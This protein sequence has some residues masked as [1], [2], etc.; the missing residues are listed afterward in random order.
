MN[1]RR[2]SALWLAGALLLTAQPVLAD[3]TAPGA[4]NSILSDFDIIGIA[5]NDYSRITGDNTAF[6]LSEHEIRRG[7]IGVAGKLFDTVKFKAE[8]DID[9]PDDPELI[10]AYISIQPNGGPFVIKLG[11]FKTAN[12]LDEQTS[13]KF[14][15]TLERAAFTDAFELARGVGAGV[16]YSGKRHTL[17]FGVFGRDMEDDVFKGYFVGGRATYE[18]IATDDL[19]VHTGVS[20]RY[21]DLDADQSPFDYSQKPVAHPAGAIVTTGEIAHSDLFVG[22]EAAV[23]KG[24]YWAAAEFGALR[25]DCVTCLSDPFL[26]GG[27]LEVGAFWNGRKN[28][29]GGKFGV[30]KI[31]NSVRDGGHG[32]FSVVARFDTLDLNDSMVNG[33]LYESITFGADWWPTSHTRLGVNVYKTHVE[34]GNVLDGLETAFATAIANGVTEEDA[35]GV[36]VRFQVHI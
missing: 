35:G 28:L 13:S 16:K 32:A 29:S 31:Y 4:G 3:D 26:P 18:P 27:Y 21:R 20:F 8:L 22:A 12:S 34:F 25:A 5:Q 2:H 7:R 23:L 17:A 11:Q 33:G 30:P 19:R 6:D 10:D 1:T 9:D 36:T 15:S 24:R 14:T